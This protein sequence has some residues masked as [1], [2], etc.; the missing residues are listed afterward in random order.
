MRQIDP[1][2]MEDEIAATA[3]RLAATL[4]EI[5]DR[6]QPQ[7]I[8]RRSAA[9][10]ADRARSA[11]TTRDGQPKVIPLAAMVLAALAGLA[12]WRRARR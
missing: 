10:A 9:V 1:K 7:E 12:I 4:Q 5:T 8:A 2:T 6:L 3:T 11:F